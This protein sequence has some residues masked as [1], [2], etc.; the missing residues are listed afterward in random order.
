MDLNHSG[1]DDNV[2]PLVQKVSDRKENERTAGGDCLVGKCDEKAASKDDLCTPSL[3]KK[4]D[5]C[6]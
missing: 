2:C 3:K 1:D 5:I 4:H 6:I